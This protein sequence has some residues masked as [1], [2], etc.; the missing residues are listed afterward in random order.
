MC[1][2]TAKPMMTDEKR[3][4]PAAHKLLIFVFFAL[5]AG[6]LVNR[7]GGD[8]DGIQI[9]LSSVFYREAVNG[10]IH[11]YNFGWQPLSYGIIR[12]CYALTGS[13][14]ACMFLPAL[15]G[16]AGITIVI[17]AMSRIGSRRLDALTLVG[18]VLLIPELLFG[19]VYMNS[20]VFGFTFA[21]AAMWFA[22]Y[23]W[24]P[25]GGP[26]GRFLQNFLA[27]A[28]FALACLCRFDFALAFPMFLFLLIRSPSAHCRAKLAALA[29]GGILILVLAQASG[30]IDVREMSRVFLRH[31]AGTKQHEAY[32]YSL[33][34]KVFLAVIGVNLFAWM[35]AGLGALSALITVVKSR[36]WIDLAVF[37]PLAI[38]LCPILSITT[39]KYLVP[40]YMFLGLFLAWVLA[41]PCVVEW[42]HRSVVAVMMTL[43]VM[44]ACFLPVRP[45]RAGGG[46]LDLTTET[47]RPTDDGARAFWG[48]VYALRAVANWQRDM[49]WLDALIAAPDD[50]LIVAPMDD[51]LLSETLSQPVLFHLA[52]HCTSLEIGPDYAL[53]RAGGK[54]ILVTE[55]GALELNV[56]DHLSPSAGPPPQ[57]TIPLEIDAVA[58]AVLRCVADGAV[59]ES[60]IV[61]RMD[62]DERAVKAHLATLQQRG[63]IKRT[64]T[65]T[66]R[67]R[68]PKLK[69]PPHPGQPRHHNQ[70]SPAIKQAADEEQS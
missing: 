44:L 57:T 40:F 67:L 31:D 65:G 60:E 63:L 6:C 17:D 66:Y 50:Q 34:E 51:W 26:D 9:V 56:K 36:R 14:D 4:L 59:T 24:T 15:F 46:M 32:H 37:V 19:T 11:F 35:A 27:G 41:R 53:A 52:R 25:S 39:P 55:P 18:V 28:L 16:A 49:G 58:D 62:S 12:L 22:V 8:W 2:D 64:E 1:P 5:F 3:S 68:Y 70:P 30:M 23:D 48:Y 33:T 21:A 42:R 13:V 10:Y 61:S 69:L 43:A 7:N 45:S 29:L 47:W 54:K 38:L 20:T